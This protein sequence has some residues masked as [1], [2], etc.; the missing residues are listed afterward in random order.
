[1]HIVEWVVSVLSIHC[2][3]L[4]VHICLLTSI[5]SLLS[6][7]VFGVNGPDILLSQQMTMSS[8]SPNP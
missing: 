1:M 3:V 6:E 5:C 2:S 4:C 7:S 8:P